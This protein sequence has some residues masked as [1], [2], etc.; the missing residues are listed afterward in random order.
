MGVS[1][2]HAEYWLGDECSLLATVL[3]PVQASSFPMLGTDT[4]VAGLVHDN[5][6]A[7]SILAKHDLSMM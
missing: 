7:A 1:T 6:A 2:C 5:R 3:W 4:L